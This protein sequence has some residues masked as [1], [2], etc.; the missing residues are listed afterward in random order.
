MTWHDKIN[1]HE[2]K[3]PSDQ[4]ACGQF[5]RTKMYTLNTQDT[6]FNDIELSSRAYTLLKNDNVITFQW[7][8]ARG[9]YF[10]N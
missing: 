9:S 10:S 5:I 7:E 4:L 1:S 6:N 3:L 2:V 8:L